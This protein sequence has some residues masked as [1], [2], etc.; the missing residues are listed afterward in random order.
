MSDTIIMNIKVDSKTLSDNDNNSN[1][2]KISDSSSN[3]NIWKSVYTTKT[4]NLLKTL[5]EF[6]KKIQ[7]IILPDDFKKYDLLDDSFDENKKIQLIEKI[8]NEIKNLKEIQ[9][10]FVDA[11][12]KINFIN[13]DLK[14]AIKEMS[15][16]Q[17]YN[18]EKY[19]KKNVELIES[20]KKK[21]EKLSD[22]IVSLN[23][24]IRK[25]IKPIKVNETEKEKEKKENKVMGDANLFRTG[26]DFYN[27]NNIFN[28]NKD[29]LPIIN[30]HNNNKNDNIRN[31]NYKYFPENSKHLSKKNALSSNKIKISPVKKTQGNNIKKVNNGLNIAKIKITNKVKSTE[32]KKEKKNK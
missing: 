18:L 8:I 13:V 15:I 19:Q 14:E 7:E 4:M 3:N 16:I 23:D 9:K 26:I 28:K 29:N 32:R 22:E 17:E 5:N 20:Y 27:P 6:F 24:Y 31:I 21:V 12:G 10:K 11:G 2:I 30:L 25:N 1:K